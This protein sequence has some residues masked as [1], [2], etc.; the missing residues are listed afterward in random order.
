MIECLMVCIAS[1]LCIWYCLK[2]CHKE[3]TTT[4]TALNNLKLYEEEFSY[5]D[6]EIKDDEDYDELLSLLDYV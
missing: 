1:M 5:L 4:S 3:T 2:K 6:V